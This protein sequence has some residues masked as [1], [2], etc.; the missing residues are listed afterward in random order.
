[1]SDNQVRVTFQPQGRAVHVLPGTKVLEAA[2]RAVLTLN[3]PC[4]GAG[5][6]G[7]C[8][9]RFTSGVCPPLPVERKW[10][11][12]DELNEGWRLAC[13]ARICAQSVITI[14][15]QSLYADGHQII[16]RSTAA[17]G[18]IE[19]A[20]RKVFVRL[21]QP[22][23]K[24]NQPDLLRLENPVGPMRADLD[25]LR[26]LP[27]DLRKGNFTGTAVLA[28]HHLIDFEQ[29]D[30]TSLCMGIAFD[31]GT[32]TLAGS[33]LDLGSG[34][35]LA[36]SS[37]I[38]PQVSYGDDVL[39]RIAHA[40]K[41]PGA[42]A[43]LHHSLTAGLAELAQKLCH[44]A[45]ANPQNVYEVAIAGNTTM[46]HLLC[47]IDPSALG[48]LPFVPAVARGLMVPA[49]ELNLPVH[50]RAMAYVYPVVGGF[51][52]GDTVAGM[53]V[54]ELADQD[55]PVLMI[56]IGTNGEIVLA[57][58]GRLLAAST[59]AGPAFEGAR[60]SCGMRA[61]AG[62]IEKVVTVDGDLRFSVIAD[63]PPVGLCGSGLID[64]AAELLTCGLISPEGRLAGP[65]ELPDSLPSAF[66]Q[67]VH[68]EDAGEASFELVPP[69]GQ[70]SAVKLTQ[71]DVRELQLAT[72]AI[73]AGV[74]I[75][76]KRAKLK[77]PDLSRVLIAG[78]FGSFIRRNNA[79][80]I[81]LLPA[82]IDHSRIL[83][84]G[85]VS[86]A[87]ARWALLSTRARRRAEQ[88]ARRAIHVEL[89]QD[90]LFSEEFA[91]ALLFPERV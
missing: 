60:I 63:T 46:Q 80:R 55:A 66:R 48:Q 77:T 72:A 90:P 15:P 54:S 5:L 65:D 53:L 86:L 41:S 91:Q 29:G 8:R 42:L 75:L 62:A 89:S 16:T 64:L 40:G 78:G 45:G 10:F 84:V 44:Q 52:G 43:E 27:A 59:A 82:G 22:T 32:T 11:T 33:L 49:R 88:L 79:Q 67:R 4:G 68:L 28:D 12:P 39:S 19:P 76:L 57:S 83:Y 18:G 6:C 37:A 69:A 3:T 70:A 1:M 58:N 35:E 50:P 24:H 26:N 51:V 25:V 74:N 47:G 36:I 7:K 85:N 73:R 13:Q 56:D 31:V 17:K 34:E 87:G 14:P 21:P 81:G 23:L 2:G 30:T 61:T 71:R 20:V 38:N 9:V